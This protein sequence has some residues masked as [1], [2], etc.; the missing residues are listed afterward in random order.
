M[1]R[2]V[3]ILDKHGASILIQA[4]TKGTVVKTSREQ[5]SRY[6]F[7][8]NDKLKTSFPPV[9]SERVNIEMDRFTG[10]LMEFIC[11]ES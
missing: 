8:D 5:D 3:N 4:R 9:T 6:N 2:E 10:C 7:L 11:L 1:S